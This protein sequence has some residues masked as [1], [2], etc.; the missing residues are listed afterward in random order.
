MSKL[1][2]PAL[3][4]LCYLILAVGVGLNIW[5]EPHRDIRTVEVFDEFD[6]TDFTTE[7]LENPD[8]A[9]EKYLAEDGNSKVVTM[10]GMV[11]DIDTN[12]NNQLVIYLKSEKHECGARFT[13]L[14]EEKEKAKDVK[15]GDKINITGAVSAGAIYDEAFGRHLDA[16][17]EQAYF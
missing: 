7:F 6:V 4:A 12:Q 16:I 8:A 17:L 2:F 15:T 1:K 10:T 3:A 13:L 9:N 5:F 14:E 11:N